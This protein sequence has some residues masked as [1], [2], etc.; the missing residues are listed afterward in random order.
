MATI[1]K[2]LEWKNAALRWTD[3][4]AQKLA[5]FEGVLWSNAQPTTHENPRLVGVSGA[6]AKLIGLSSETFWKDR[7]A[8]A[9]VWS[10]NE[11][12][13]GASRPW[14]QCYGG[15]QFGEWAGQLGDGRAINLG[16]IESSG[17]SWEVQLKGAGR[18]QYSRFGDGFA[19]R[20]SSIREYLA[21]EN[22]HALGVPSSRSL[23][24]VFTDRVVQR[25]EP[26]LGAIVT[27]LAPSWVRFGS[28]ELPVSR[29][30][31]AAC[32][33]LADY[34]LEHNYAHI[35]GNTAADRYTQLF[36][37]I[38]HRT[39][40]TVARW[41]AVG[42]CH[43][44]M[45]TDNMSILGLTIDY[46][47]FAFM[48]AYDPQFVCN[49]SDVTGRYSFVEQ[50]RIAL[51]NLLRLAAPFKGLIGSIDTIADILNSFA[52]EYR[53]SY[54]ELM[55]QKLGLFNVA[56]DNDLALIIDPF[57]ALLQRA[58]ADYT[59]SMRALCDA[60]I[61]FSKNSECAAIDRLIDRMAA[62]QNNDDSWKKDMRAFL[63]DVYR[64]RLREDVDSNNLSSFQDIAERMRKA[65][66]RFILRNWV[67]Q[68]VINRAA[69][70]DY[71]C[72]DHVLD[73]IT[74]YAF[75]D[76]LPDHLKAEQAYGGPVP[77]WGQ[78]LQSSCSS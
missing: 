36:R 32:Q 77:K 69:N 66:P 70:G 71:D 54:A 20:R 43:G 44:V 51:W 60:P 61:L 42:F 68:D 3:S 22:L 55:R 74:T 24:L 48:D 11:L 41:Q 46:G 25:E 50:P 29:N 9:A 62:P 6:G 78:G 21:A 26:E 31:H 34:V 4:F 10:G 45:N 35:V 16:E 8:A 57:L 37:E 49:R 59:L 76:T 28:F 18:T 56:K 40:S 73:L 53:R 38:T 30:D 47:P 1:T 75:S 63:T 52:D 27:R 17:R 12:I 39:A 14:A 72:I 2:S 7:S 23:A 65:N 5:D 64:P 13:P 19:V 33:R 67:A 58:G 15:H